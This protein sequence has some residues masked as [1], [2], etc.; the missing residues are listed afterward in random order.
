M[1]KKLA[2]IKYL[3]NNFKILEKGDHVLC[4]VSGKKIPLEN[5]NYWNVDTQE[6]YYSYKEAHLKKEEEN[7]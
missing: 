7:S 1:L 6:A 4:A 5:L 3:P 2:K